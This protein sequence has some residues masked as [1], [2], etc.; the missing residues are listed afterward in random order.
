MLEIAS[1]D[2]QQIVFKRFK[3]ETERER[4]RETETEIKSETK[5]GCYVRAGLN[6]R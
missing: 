1:F 5:T 6:E 3:R 2:T 4:E